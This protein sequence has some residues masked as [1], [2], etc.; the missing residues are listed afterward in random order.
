[1]AGEVVT[2]MLVEAADKDVMLPAPVTKLHAVEL[3]ASPGLGVACPETANTLPH[4]VWLA[5]ALATPICND[6]CF[7]LIKSTI[8][9]VGDGEVF[10]LMNKDFTPRLVHGSM[11]PNKA[12]RSM[13]ASTKRFAPYVESPNAV[14]ETGTVAALVEANIE[15]AGVVEVLST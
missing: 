5:P 3:T 10:V 7:G 13:A 9:A 14:K 8:V 6:T 12:V 4:C 2:V 1:M 11:A 15:P